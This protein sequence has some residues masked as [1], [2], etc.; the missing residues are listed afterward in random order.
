M[1]DCVGCVALRVRLKA[2]QEELDLVKARLNRLEAFS[3]VCQDTP[4]ELH[5]YLR[6]LHAEVERLRHGT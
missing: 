3:A 2:R 4:E 1:S 6:A 5:K